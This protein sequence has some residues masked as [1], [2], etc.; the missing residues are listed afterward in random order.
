MTWRDRGYWAL[1]AAVVFLWLNQSVPVP[2]WRKS[3]E[4]VFGSGTASIAETLQYPFLFLYRK[5]ADEELYFALANAMLGHETNEVVITKAREGSPPAFSLP[6]PPA[7]GAWH[8]PYNEVPVE[9]PPLMVPFIIIPRL[10][11]SSFK[12]YFWLF[13]ALMALLLFISAFVVARARKIPARPAALWGSVGLLLHGAIAIERLDPVATLP[14]ALSASALLR[15]KRDQAAFWI[16]LAGAAKFLPILFVLPMLAID[17]ACLPAA[18]RPETR[19]EALARCL[20]FAG[21]AGGTFIAGL[22]PFFLFSSHALSDVLAYHGLRGLHGESF[23]GA[24]CAAWSLVFGDGHPAEHSFGSFNLV[25]A[26]PAL[27]AKLLTPALVVALVALSA[28]LVKRRG[29]T[30]ELTVLLCLA[31]VWAFGKVFSPQYLTWALPFVPYLAVRRAWAPLAALFGLFFVSQLYFRGY[32]DAVYMLKP[33]GVITL[34]VRNGLLV[35]L[36]WSL[37]KYSSIVSVEGNAE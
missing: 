6:I 25:G 32:F 34:I 1:L 3:Q 19:R 22:L 30:V 9:Y 33:I 36:L 15:E 14:I 27:L 13:G 26:A 11:T 28:W 7:D 24:F 8:A 31:S 2:E 10:F 29:V 16:G 4:R 20:R 21:I 18:L 23:L 5:S 35:A 12:A 17:P 37:V